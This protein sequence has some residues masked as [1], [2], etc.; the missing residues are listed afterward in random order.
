MYIQLLPLQPKSLQP[1]PLINKKELAILGKRPQNVVDHQLKAIGVAANLI[2]VRQYGRAIQA[3]ILHGVGHTVSHFAS[4]N[5]IV[6]KI[7]DLRYML[8]DVFDVLYL[9]NCVVVVVFVWQNTLQ[10]F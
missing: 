8:R 7:S 4:F 2:E 10:A 1:N 6:H 5:H 3:G 9:H